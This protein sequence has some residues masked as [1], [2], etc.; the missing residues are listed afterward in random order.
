MPLGWLIGV[1]GGGGEMEWERTRGTDRPPATPNWARAA[2]K[3]M[4]RR[5]RRESMGRERACM[6]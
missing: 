3:G 2:V 6:V 1:G 5:G 4:W